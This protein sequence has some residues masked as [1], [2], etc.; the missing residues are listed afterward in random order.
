MVKLTFLLGKPLKGLNK[1]VIIRD[2]GVWNHC[3]SCELDGFEVVSH[4]E[5][6]VIVALVRDTGG[7]DWVAVIEMEGREG[8]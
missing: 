3:G 2:G 4:P 7:F 6:A 1:S 5:K 8:I